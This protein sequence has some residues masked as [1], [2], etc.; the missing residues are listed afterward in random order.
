MRIRHYEGLDKATKKPLFKYC[1][2]SDTTQLNNLALSL[3]RPNIKP[4]DQNIS[5]IPLSQESMVKASKADLR[6]LDQKN[7][8]I[9]Q[10]SSNQVLNR[11]LLAVVV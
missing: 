11:K 8:I 1:R 7:K 6:P 2:V 10:N 5:A 3:S 9:E 4:L